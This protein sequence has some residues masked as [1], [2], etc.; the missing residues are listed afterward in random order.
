MKIVLSGGKS[1]PLAEVLGFL[2]LAEADSSAYRQAGMF[3]VE[4]NANKQ[5][6]NSVFLS[7]VNF[8]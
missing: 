6:N 7:F 5:C 2:P 4:R 8:C 3:V 1:M